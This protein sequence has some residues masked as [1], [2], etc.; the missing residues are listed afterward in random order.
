MTFPKFIDI[1]YNFM[2]EEQIVL[3]FKILWPLGALYTGDRDGN[4]YSTL[5]YVNIVKLAAKEY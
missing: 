5:N 3:F 1:F 2:I 4:I